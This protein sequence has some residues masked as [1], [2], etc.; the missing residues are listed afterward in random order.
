MACGARV[1][2][3]LAVY[4]LHIWSKVV[5]RFVYVCRK[6]ILKKKIIK[7]DD[8]YQ[9]QVSLTDLALFDISSQFSF[10]SR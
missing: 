2:G 10:L 7:S 1:S 9:F 6:A 3:R 8:P 5:G 4:Q